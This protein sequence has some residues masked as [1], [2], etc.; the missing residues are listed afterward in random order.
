MTD[1]DPPPVSSTA[2]LP[3]PAPW[4]N[5]QRWYN[6]LFTTLSVILAT[7]TVGLLAWAAMGGIVAYLVAYLVVAAVGVAFTLVGRNQRKART[8]LPTPS[9]YFIAATLTAIWM[10][11]AAAIAALLLLMAAGSGSS[12]QGGRGRE[13]F[14][15]IR[16]DH[17][18]RPRGV[19]GMSAT[20][21]F[22][23]GFP[24][25]G[26]TTMATRSAAS[27]STIGHS[28]THGSNGTATVNT[29]PVGSQFHEVP[30][31][32]PGTGRQNGRDVYANGK[33]QHTIANNGSTI[34][35]PDGRA[36]LSE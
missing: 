14:T 12:K 20:S 16:P 33:Y 27:P 26:H 28:S 30:R 8:G 31:F 2:V 15:G 24:S 3:P 23:P 17:D 6:Q 35:D 4:W 10:I 7:A 21:S 36:V 19:S 22:R 29:Y 25:T 11:P 18:W 13:A 32:H 1:L 34:C 9:W 5:R